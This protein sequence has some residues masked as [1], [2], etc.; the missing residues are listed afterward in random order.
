MFISATYKF[1][2]DKNGAGLRDP[3]TWNV[4]LE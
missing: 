3:T 4:G 1:T 2:D